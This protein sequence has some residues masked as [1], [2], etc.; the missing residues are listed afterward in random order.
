MNP[1]STGRFSMVGA[2]CGVMALLVSL[3]GV[4][5][6]QE[7][8][9]L[10]SDIA[11]SP[12]REEI[13]RIGRAGCA[14]GFADDTFQ[15][16]GTVT[17]QQFAFWT[18]NCGGRLGSDAGTLL[19]TGPSADLTLAEVGLT[20]G[21]TTQGGNALPGFVLV[22]GTARARTSDLSGCPCHVSAYLYNVAG[23]EQSFVSEATLH[24]PPDHTTRA[25]VTLP[26]VSEFLVAPGATETFRLVV[27]SDDPQGP[28]IS[29]EGS[30]TALYV[31]FGAD[32]DRAFDAD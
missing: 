19:V 28:D 16:R 1:S 27:T 30:V 11:N 2:V 32:G 8:G 18:N 31:P 4:A 21:A 12:F 24:S 29:F 23:N 5:L 3:G 22:H 7:G 15:P 25:S 26:V 6:G 9:D 10:F 20:A 14:S 17:R 13:N